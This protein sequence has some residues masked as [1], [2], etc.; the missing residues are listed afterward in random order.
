MV[1]NGRIL[2]VTDD[3]RALI[4]GV[5]MDSLGS[6]S[7]LLRGNGEPDGSYGLSG[8]Y[9]YAHPNDTFWYGAPGPD[10]IYFAGKTSVHVAGQ[11]D[12][13]GFAVARS[14][15]PLFQSGFDG[16]SADP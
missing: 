12:Q 9:E 14:T 2:R 4:G 8:I 1:S 16:A 5:R 3:G 6:V 7:V 15:W 11:S 10:H 13:D